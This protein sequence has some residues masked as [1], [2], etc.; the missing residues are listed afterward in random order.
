MTFGGTVP[1]KYPEKL[2]SIRINGQE[3]NQLQD[4]GVRMDIRTSSLNGL[5]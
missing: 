2:D 4:M 1:D 3:L 5:V